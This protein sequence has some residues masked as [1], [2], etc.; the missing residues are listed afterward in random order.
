MKSI[1][2]VL[3]AASATFIILAM[4]ACG[5][6]GGGGTGGT[7]GTGNSAVSGV[8]VS[9]RVITAKGSVFVNGIEFNTA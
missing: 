4:G 3:Q 2:R 5:G 8:A 7:G 9:Q 1:V 6:G